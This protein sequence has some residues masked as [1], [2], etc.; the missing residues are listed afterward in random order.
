MTDPTLVESV[1]EASQAQMRRVAAQ[2]ASTSGDLHGMIA[3]EHQQLYALD[4]PAILAAL[5]EAESLRAQVAASQAR[6]VA[7][8]EALARVRQTIH[9]MD[10]KRL[11]Q[12]VPPHARCELDVLAV[13]EDALSAPTA[14][15]ALRAML[16]GAWDSGWQHDTLDADT[17]ERVRG[18]FV[19]R[20]LG[21]S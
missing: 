4:L 1:R 10:V 15:A 8:R 3:Y 9:Q 16:E 18:N 5:T 20:V 17:A 14:T 21:G 19:D 12:Q 2:K 6:E 11:T 7:L 13:V